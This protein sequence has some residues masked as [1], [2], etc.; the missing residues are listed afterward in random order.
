MITTPKHHTPYADRAQ[1]CEQALEGV[2]KRIILLAEQ[3]GWAPEET[4]LALRKILD[5][6]TPHLPVTLTRH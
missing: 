6:Q 4:A 5:K 2:F 3:Y 1:D